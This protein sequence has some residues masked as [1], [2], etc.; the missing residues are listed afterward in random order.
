MHQATS[1]KIE[2][3]GELPPIEGAFLA[4]ARP[5]WTDEDYDTFWTFAAKVKCWIG[6]GERAVESHCAPVVL[7]NIER[8][9]FDALPAKEWEILVA[10]SREVAMRNMRNE[11]E[12]RFLEDNLFRPR[13]I[14]C[15]HIK[16]ASLAHRYYPDPTLRLHRDVDILLA[17]DDHLK[18]IQFGAEHGYRFFVAGRELTVSRDADI[19]ALHKFGREVAMLS[20]RLAVIELHKWIDKGMRVFPTSVL[21]ENSEQQDFPGGAIRVLPTNWLFC[22][23][24]YHGCRHNWDKLIWMIDL[25]ALMRS[26]DFAWSETRI[27]A[28]RAGIA[29][30][31]DAAYCAARKF[32][33]V[34]VA[35]LEASR[36]ARNDK[37]TQ[38][39]LAVLRGNSMARTRETRHCRRQIPDMSSALWLGDGFNGLRFSLNRIIALSS[40]SLDDYRVLPLDA[41]RTHLYYYLRPVIFAYRRIRSVFGRRS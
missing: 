20:P 10:F 25:I 31:V 39:S 21:F 1:Q 24:A 14:D 37:T 36:A 5:Y 41:R 28:R 13:K 7:R 6:F 33:K 40:P 15:V 27:I 17:E 38:I 16:G 9:G 3:V 22:F 2:S 4:L 26:D 8:C 32:E 30:M 35:L 23:L 29:S 34:D 19:A 12:I 18:V 11:A